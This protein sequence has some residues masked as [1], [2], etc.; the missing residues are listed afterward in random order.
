MTNYIASRTSGT[1]TKSKKAV[2]DSLDTVGTV[3]SNVAKNPLPVVETIALTIVTGDPTIAAAAVSALNGGDPKQIATAAISASVGA[4]VGASA[5][6]AASSAGASSAVAQIASSAAGASSAAVTKALASGQNLGQALTAGLTSGAI[7]GLAAAGT[8]A[9]KSAVETPIAGTG[10]KA[11]QGQGT[12]LFAQDQ[13]VTGL[14]SNVPTTGGQGLY[15]D[16]NAILPSSLSQYGTAPSQQKAGTSGSLIPRTESLTSGGIESVKTGPVMTDT[17]SPESSSALRTALG[18]GISG[19]FAPS[20]TTP[21][22][23]G[24]VTISGSG[25]SPGSQA[26]GQALRVGDAGAPVFGGDKE[27]GKK[28]GWNVESLRYMGQES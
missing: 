7:G 16:P 5:G 14:T 18:L 26:L 24:G 21:S 28:S 8:E 19:A 10:L 6:G 4:Q 17:L 25:Q 15:G 13:G 9:I 27:E 11:T 3:V 2:S 23:G 12:Q 20:A 1:T 22:G